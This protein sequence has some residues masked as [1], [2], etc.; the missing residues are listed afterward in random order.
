MIYRFHD[1]VFQRM[2]KGSMPNIM[3]QNG[4]Q[5]CIT[6][7]IRDR[8]IFPGDHLQ[9]CIH[10][11]CCTERVLKPGMVSGRINVE[12]ESELPDP[13]QSLKP[14]MINEIID[15]WGLKIDKPVEGVINDLPFISFGTEFFFHQDNGK[16]LLNT[17]LRLI[18]WETGKSQNFTDNEYVS[19]Q[20]I[21]VLENIIYFCARLWE[22]W[23]GDSG[24]LFFNFD[25]LIDHTRIE[26]I[27][28]EALKDSEVFLVDILVSRTNVIQVFIDHQ[29]GVSLDNCIAVHRVIED[30]VDR[31]QEDYE[32]QVSSPGLGQPIR[33]FRQYLKAIGEKMEIILE[34][35]DILKGALLEARPA[36][37][38]KEAELVVRQTGTKRKPA[39]EE[40]LVI[41]MSRIKTAKVEI[42]FKQV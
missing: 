34:D 24:P 29:A 11:V 9:R 5:C 35:G 16:C 39:P 22:Y 36:E 23:I 12:G 38:G 15:H 17:I 27:V 2:R 8:V 3:E 37:T 42:D 20:R 4:G 41:Q 19:G 21:A 1:T 14:R 40:P 31:E 28:N 25:I 33:V 13:S 26:N 6:F 18:L 32:L 10:Q 7:L 30:Q